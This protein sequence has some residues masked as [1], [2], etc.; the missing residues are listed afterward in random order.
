MI[1][2]NLIRGQTTVVVRREKPWGGI[3][4]I[5]LLF[6]LISVLLGGAACVFFWI[7]NRPPQMVER[8]TVQR[9]A[10]K[11]IPHQVS[12]L[13][14]IDAV[15]TVVRDKYDQSAA[16][17][18]LDRL[19]S[20][21]HLIATERFE[22]DRSFPS[23]LVKRFNARLP[24]GVVFYHIRLN[25]DATFFIHG[26][27]SNKHLV[28]IFRDDLKSE[29][30]FIKSVDEIN[31]PPSRYSGVRFILKGLADFNLY[32]RSVS[33]R[34]ESAAL[35]DIELFS[36]VSDRLQ[37]LGRRCGVS[38]CL[39]PGAFTVDGRHRRQSADF[40]FVS[41]YD[42]AEKVIDAIFADGLRI[43]YQEII[44]ESSGGGLVK[45]TA[46]VIFDCKR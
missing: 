23:M 17:K 35:Q 28:E 26:R 39:S 18:P 41:G 5:F 43:G 31:F 22:F 9:K 12:H 25:C 11:A 32:I 45:T 24:E 14:A 30:N 3:L 21:Q 4:R 2:I 13:P 6:F 19:A 44:F 46:R 7:R 8:P 37:K 16:V 42:A 40:T 1:R 29:T 36:V 33:N 34:T 15:E 38:I 20:R 27:S 10:I